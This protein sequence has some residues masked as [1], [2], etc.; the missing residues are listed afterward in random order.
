MTGFIVFR[1]VFAFPDPTTL[2]DLAYEERRSY[3][4]EG[5]GLLEPGK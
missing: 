3:S 2:T 1:P 4:L 5:Y